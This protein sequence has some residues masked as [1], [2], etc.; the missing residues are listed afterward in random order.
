M[1]NVTGNII[2]NR[3]RPMESLLKK[4]RSNITSAIF[5]LAIILPANLG[6]AAETLRV[7]Y[8]PN[9]THAQPL[10]G[11]ANGAFRNELGSAVQLETKTFTA[12]PSAVEAL[13]A[14]AID[15]AY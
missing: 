1:K 10:V 3:T 8:F 15:L 7:G 13:F 2:Y 9:I 14:Q 11:F 6:A 5:G 4:Y 12:G